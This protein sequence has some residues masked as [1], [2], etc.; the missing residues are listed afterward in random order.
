MHKLIR[1]AALAVF[2]VCLASCGGNQAPAQVQGMNGSRAMTA[3][4]SVAVEYEDL[5]QQIYVGYFGR[6][7][8]PGGLANYTQVLR[9]ANAPTTVRGLF[10]VYGW[11]PAVRALLDNFAASEE[12]QQLYPTCA[13]IGCDYQ[14]IYALYHSLFS[15]EPDIEGAQ[16]WANALNGNGAT[17]AAVLLSV[18]AGAQ[19]PDAA[20]VARKVR[21]A[22]QFTRALEAA[23]Q[24]SAYSGQL[25]ALIAR[26]MMHDIPALADD[27][28]VQAK[29]EATIHRLTSLASGTVEEVAPG[30]R[31]ILVLASAERLSDSGARLSVLAD[32]MADDLNHLRQGGPA[33]SVTVARAADSISAIRGQLKGYDGVILVGRIPVPTGL[34]GPFLDVY[35]LPDCPDFQIDSTGIVQNALALHSADPRCQNGLIVSV[36]RGTTPPTEF[37][38]LANKLD[39]MIAYHRASNTANASWVRR[40]RFIEAGW[41][42]GPDAQ[43][44]DQSSKWLGMNLYGA[45]AV[46]YLNEGSSLQRRDAFLDCIAQNIEMCGANL[47]GS[48]QFLVF[49]GPGALG[50]FYS[51]DAMPWYGTELAAQSVKAKYIELSSCST[52]D[53]LAERSI[54]TSLLMQGRAL[55]T[56]GFTDVTLVAGHYEEDVI[57][58]EY[59]LLQNGSTFAEALYGRMEGT[60]VSIQGDPYIT[61]RPAPTGAQPRLLI[62]GKHYNDGVTTIPVVMSDAVGGASSV[63]VL[64]FS[65]RGDADLH[66]RIGSTFAVTGVDYGTANGGEWEF[67]YNAQYE[68]DYTQIF[69]DGRVLAWPNFAIEQN[70]GAMPVTL[71]PGQ[72]VAISY[73]LSVRTGADGKPKRPGLYTGQLTITSDDPGSARIYLAMQGRVR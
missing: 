4:P 65:N 72:S 52:Q 66:V 23:G 56:R 7:A 57:K 3:S 22:A 35:R 39:Q 5:V 1:S 59:A 24:G 29:I 50:E 41:F 11:S 40:F 73:K 70:G 63:R 55:L 67:G 26:S 9:T 68:T 27:A 46:S 71:K 30:S 21:V 58:N 13:W 38:E 64:S 43:W 54:G 20:L 69:S 6:P 19:G 18:L 15:R 45:N 51:S 60:P 37:I 36:L 53:F 14:W 12:S 44:G 47:H 42:G 10:D 34:V 2:L 62:D 31:K 8:D 33:W 17:R 25:A 61:M 28:A 32:A 48:P 49:E 16:F